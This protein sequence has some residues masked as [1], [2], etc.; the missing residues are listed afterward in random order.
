MINKRTDEELAREMLQEDCRRDSK[1]PWNLCPLI[2]FVWSS[3]WLLTQAK[4][5]SYTWDLGVI[6]AKICKKHTFSQTK[7]Y[8]FLFKMKQ[9]SINSLPMSSIGNS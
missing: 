4:A 2:V 7:L 6:T 3:V 9:T 8:Y 1:N 5:T